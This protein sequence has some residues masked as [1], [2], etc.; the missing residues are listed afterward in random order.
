[1]W[2]TGPYALTLSEPYLEYVRALGRTVKFAARTVVRRGLLVRIKGLTSR[3]KSKKARIVHLLYRQGSLVDT[4][5]TCESGM[6]TIGGCA[7]AIAVLRHILE[8]KTGAAVPLPT[9]SR[10]VLDAMLRSNCVDVLEE[11]DNDTDDECLD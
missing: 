10:Q 2:A 4:Y 1:M 7:H 9:K 6:R 3:F 5:C 8:L 11:E